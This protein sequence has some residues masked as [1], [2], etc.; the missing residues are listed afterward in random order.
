M[1]ITKGLT[2]NSAYD[3]MEGFE[4][5][6][7]GSK[8]AK[9]ADNA[10]VLMIRNIAYKWKQPIGYFFSE[11]QMKGEVVAKILKS[12]IL[13]VENIGLNVKVCI[14]D[15]GTNNQKAAR[16]LGVTQICPIFL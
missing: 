2:Y 5:V 1:C 8:S 6:H 13:E 7:V 12:S 10:L 4:D 3:A 14:C 11:G 16:I 15:Q 9:V